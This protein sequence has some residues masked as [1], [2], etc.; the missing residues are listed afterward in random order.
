MSKDSEIWGEFDRYA[1]RLR[2]DLDTL[3][4]MPIEDRKRP[5]VYDIEKIRKCNDYLVTVLHWCEN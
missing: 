1:K 4:A 3:L 2:K 5:S